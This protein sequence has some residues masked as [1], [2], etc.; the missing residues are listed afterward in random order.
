MARA[1]RPSRGPLDTVRKSS[2]EGEDDACGDGVGD[3][4]DDD[5]DGDRDADG[6]FG[7]DDVGDTGGK[8]S[9]V[10]ESGEGDGTRLG[11]LPPE[12]RLSSPSLDRLSGG[13]VPFATRRG[14]GAD[15]SAEVALT[16]YAA[17]SKSFI[18]AGVWTCNTPWLAGLA[19]R[20]CAKNTLA[21]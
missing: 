15:V 7:G 9:S 11:W 13:R 3:D 4:D 10:I 21:S 14:N 12:S 8:D 19:G 6:D 20:A 5:D 17:K 2:S 16:A 18:G 1:Q